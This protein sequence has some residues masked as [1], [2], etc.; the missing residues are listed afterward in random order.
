VR[1][2]AKLDSGLRERKRW[3]GPA[4]RNWN[5]ATRGDIAVS[6][7]GLERNHLFLNSL[8][9]RFHDVSGISGLD[10]LADSRGFVVF[11]YDRDGWQDVAV[12]NTNAPLL[13]IYRN[14]IAGRQGGPGRANRVIAL[15]LVGGNRTDRPAPGFSNRDGYGAM[16]VVSAGGLKLTR[17]HRCGEGFAAQN[18]ATVLIGIGARE[19]AESVEVRWPSGRVQ[20][21]RDVPAGT[22][23]TVYENPEESTSQTAFSRAVYRRPA[24]ARPPVRAADSQPRHLKLRSRKAAAPAEGGSATPRLRM[25]TTMATWCATCRRELPQL[26]LL[27]ESLDAEALELLAVP[28]DAEDTPEKL[29]R[30][31][32]KHKPAYE[33]LSDLTPEEVAEV[34]GIVAAELEPDLLPVSIITDAKGSVLSTLPGVPSLSQLR[35][36]LPRKA[37]VGH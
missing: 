8:G 25:Y 27:R 23:L 31:V 16:V 17:E 37:R 7:S 15:Q 13:Q 21:V 32:A 33:M 11:D 6:L 12:V 24:P 1:S 30:Y 36:L 19:V 28:I 9:Q 2:D 35:E 14:E 22:L 34:Q 10:T 26:Q 20:R 5:R 29:G 3:A 4:L 18:S